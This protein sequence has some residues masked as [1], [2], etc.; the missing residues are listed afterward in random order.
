MA[1]MASDA[2]TRRMKANEYAVLHGGASAHDALDV[3]ATTPRGTLPRPYPAALNIAAEEQWQAQAMSSG[4]EDLE[5]D[6]EE[7]SSSE[8][9]NEV[10]VEGP[11]GQARAHAAAKQPVYHARVVKGLRWEDE[12]VRGRPEPDLEEYFSEFEIDTKA[13]IDIC[14]K[15][16]AYLSAK[17]A[18][19]RPPA[20]KKQKK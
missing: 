2:F 15:Y 8:S 4:D 6:G 19:N 13:R 9:D 3:D 12:E 18:S 5:M 7:L 11:V 14:R 10:V 16:A 1:Q 17:S 20:A